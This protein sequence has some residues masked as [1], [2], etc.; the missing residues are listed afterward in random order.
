MQYQWLQ[1]QRQVP[2]RNKLNVLPINYS[3]TAQHTCTGGQLRR[4]SA[5]R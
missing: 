3:V 1:R 4:L 5:K 2:S